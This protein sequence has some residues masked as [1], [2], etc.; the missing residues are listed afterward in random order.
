MQIYKDWLRSYGVKFE[1][2]P[3]GLAFKYQGANFILWDNSK[4]QQYLA[5]SMPN[6]WDVD[7]EEVKVLRAANKINGDI[8]AIKAVIRDNAVWLN[9]E[10][11]I[12]NTPDIEDFMD[13]ILGILLEC[14]M[15]FAFAMQNG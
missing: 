15:K 7:G 11:F 1:E 13:R 3:F 5:L 9:I 4:D 14:R 10:M 2:L 6:I 12:D 8:K